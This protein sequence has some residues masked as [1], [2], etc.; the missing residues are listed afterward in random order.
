MVTG[1]AEPCFS[2]PV[3]FGGCKV[4]EVNVVLLGPWEEG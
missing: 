2:A 4:D 1:F 3:A